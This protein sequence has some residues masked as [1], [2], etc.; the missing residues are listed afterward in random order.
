MQFA[1]IRTTVVAFIHAP[2]VALHGLAQSSENPNSLYFKAC[3][4]V[5]WIVLA[6]PG[7]VGLLWTSERG[8]L[9]FPSSMTG[10]LLTHNHFI[11]VT[12]SHFSNSQIKWGVLVPG[13]SH[14]VTGDRRNRTCRSYVRALES[15]PAEG[16]MNSS[17]RLQPLIVGCCLALRIECCNCDRR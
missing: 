14:L 10:V 3:L 1:L 6:P 5:L 8:S 2:V 12:R 15:D 16:A 11:D 9:V 13:Y 4:S 17:R 7:A